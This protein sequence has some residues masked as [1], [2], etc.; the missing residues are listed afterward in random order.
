[1]SDW[2]SIESK[3]G[4]EAGARSP[5]SEVERSEAGREVGGPVSGLGRGNRMTPVGIADERT[6]EAG[7]P[8]L[9]YPW[10]TKV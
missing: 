9:E 3:S 2:R 4:R 7:H 6:V 5:R 10:L 1:M 8:K